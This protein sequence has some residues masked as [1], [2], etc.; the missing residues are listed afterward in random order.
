MVGRFGDRPMFGTGV[1]AAVVLT[2]LPSMGA[3]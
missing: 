3:R 2:I 1:G